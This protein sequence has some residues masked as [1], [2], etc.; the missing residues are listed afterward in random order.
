MFTQSLWNSFS[1]TSDFP[2]LDKELHADVAI[3]GGG[4]T[5]ITT[6]QK[7]SE[8]G[9][10]VV[11]LEARKVGGGTTSHS[12]GNLYYTID[13]ILSSLK[14]KYDN[15]I[16][17]KIVSSRHDAINLIENN[18]EKFGIDCDFE[19]VPWYLYSAT[20]KDSQKIEQELETAVEAGVEMTEARQEEIPFKMTR[21]V[22]VGGQAYFNA[23]RYVQELAKAIQSESCTIH[24]NT[25][26]QEIEDD[27]NGVELRTTGGTVKAKYA[28]HATHTPKGVKVA[29][30]T[31][32]GPYREYG[33]AARLN[34]GNYPKGM[35]WGYH[36]GQKYSVRSYK[37][38]AETFIIAVGQPHKV[39]QAEDNTKH[40]Q[41]LISFLKEHFDL[42][43][44][45]HR[46]G[47]QHYK[48]ADKLP[49]IGQK[50]KGSRI[51]IA[52]G[53]STDGLTYG[54]LSAM[55][56]S[57]GISGKE[58]PYTQ[59][60]AASRFTPGKSAKEFLKENVNVA[61]QLIKDLPF[62]ED[63]EQLKH[64]KNGEG[65]IIEKDG[66]KVAASKSNSGELNFH[67]AFCTHMSCVVHWNNA[68][69]TW[70]CP[71]HGSR[72]NQEGG[73]LEGPAVQPL[74]KIESTGFSTTSIKKD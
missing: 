63:E 2:K 16:I 62:S 20:D 55:L 4:I 67:S 10:K 8:E 48:P 60:Y 59:M 50:T 34:S 57:D 53:F 7:L 5:G 1:G 44:I 35:F 70:D 27:D 6:A 52:T 30:H 11:V 40:I 46:W 65:K 43:E 9:L 61:A 71:C 21:G 14:D 72:F 17:R 45:T 31:V 18:I 37:R 25:R 54:T 69:K 22:K 28:V 13:Q 15:E 33:V 47:G 39:G 3:V 66:H 56:I 68:E 24:E 19:R 74:K 36:D 26:V 41:N 23:M 58:N 51:Y 12:T 29:F 32:L 49:Y 73:V 42:G 64:L 38:G